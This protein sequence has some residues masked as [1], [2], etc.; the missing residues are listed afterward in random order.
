MFNEYQSAVTTA[1]ESGK[2]KNDEYDTLKESLTIQI[3]TKMEEECKNIQSNSQL[4]DYS[5]IK[6][7]NEMTELRHQFDKINKDLEKELDEIKDNFHDSLIKLILPE[8][9]S[10][11]NSNN[12]IGIDL[13]INNGKTNRT[14]DRLRKKLERKNKNIK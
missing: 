12:N 14:R 11:S 13:L 6:H 3:K 10:N 1:I 2:N 9:D 7:Y 4:K 5:P 8:P